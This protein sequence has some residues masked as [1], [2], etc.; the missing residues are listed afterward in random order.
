MLGLLSPSKFSNLA[1]LRNVLK[2]LLIHG[3]ILFYLINL[4]T[5]SIDVAMYV[6]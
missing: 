3:V 6:S 5:P 1:F 2:V 4:M